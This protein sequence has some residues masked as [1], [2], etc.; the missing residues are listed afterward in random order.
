MDRK[1]LLIG[2]GLIG[3]IILIIGAFIIIS[4]IIGIST[5][6]SNSTTNSSEDWLFF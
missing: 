1:K 2:D 5:Y 4:P 6:F 3:I